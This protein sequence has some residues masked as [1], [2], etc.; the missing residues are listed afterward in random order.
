MVIG[1]VIMIKYSEKRYYLN[2]DS[3]STGTG[4]FKKRKNSKSIIHEHITLFLK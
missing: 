1:N 4:C 3:G 2:D